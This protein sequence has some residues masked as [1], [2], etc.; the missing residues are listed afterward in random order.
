MSLHEESTRIPLIVAA[1]GRKPGVATGLAQQIDIYPTLAELAGLPVPGH[2]Q[3]ESL[4]A[5]LDDPTGEVHEEVYCFKRR[6]HLVRTRRWA[7]LSYEDDTAELYDM[8]EDP[9]QFTNLAGS[10]SH[11]EVLADMER[12]L[13]AKL[14]AIG[15]G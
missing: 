1:P 7:F 3:G 12:R 10:P 4:A 13:R 15:G 14:T 9:H 6:G 11:A 2:V 5:L 8:E